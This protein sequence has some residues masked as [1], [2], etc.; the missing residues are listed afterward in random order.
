M[1]SVKFIRENADRVKGDVVLRNVS[2]P[3]DELIAADVRHRTL[4]V[5]VEDLRAQKNV[6]SKEIGRTKDAGER[7]RRIAASREVGDRLA[8]LEKRLDAVAA[9]VHEMVMDIPNVL[10]AGIPHGP[11]EDSNVVLETF[12]AMPEFDFEPAAHWDIGPN[13]DGI[14]FE[15]G[16]KMSGT[17]FFVLR[18][19]IARL[20]RS[21]IQWMLNFHIDE[22]GLTEHYLP[23]MLTEESLFASG[24]LPKFRENLYGDHEDDYLFAPSAEAPFANLYRGEI[25]PPGSL[26]MRF[27]A[28]SPCFRREKMSAGRDTRGLKRVHQFEKV[29]M[30]TFCDPAD[31]DDELLRLLERAKAVPEQLKIPYRVLELCSGD[32]DFKATKGFDVE[33]W[34]PGIREWL[35]VSS[36]SNTRDF[37]ARRSNT[38]FRPEEG[39]GTQFPHM[40]NGSGLGLPR[41]LISVIENY[42]E[43]DGGITVPDVLRP[44]MGCDRIPGPGEND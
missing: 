21:L 11:D 43:A 20:H 36:I 25:L 18:G 26:P 4:L 42:Q 29:E 23:V 2:A 9:E 35:E 5:E 40:L 1:L 39:A 16:A 37:Q 14:D 31:S 15:R 12:G 10:D 28:H 7:D 24:H 13:M 34:A 19:G 30:F 3:I 38:R 8:G 32:L 17:R 41:T 6:V 44:Y 33:M 22:G 27:V